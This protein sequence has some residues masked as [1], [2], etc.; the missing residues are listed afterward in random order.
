MKKTMLF[1]T[2]SLVLA[3][4]T[5]CGEKSSGSKLL[6][7]EVLVCNESNYQ[8]D[9]GQH[10]AWV[11]IFNKSYTSADLAGWYLK[12]HT[13]T[14]ADTMSYFIP[15]GDVLT[16]VKPRQHALFWADGHPNKG[17]FHTSFTLD[18]TQ[19]NWIGL[20]DG[21]G[22]LVDQ[23]TV[24][25]GLLAA[26]Q[27]Y[28]R[29]ND[30]ADEWEVKGASSDKY[31]TPS[32][33][34]QTLDS[35]YKRDKFKVQDS[36]GIGMAITAM[37]VVFSGL[38][39]LFVSFMLAGRIALNMHHRHKNRQQAAKEARK[40][41]SAATAKAASSK[42][43]AAQASGKAPEGEVYAAIAMA[44]YELQANVHDVESNVLT[45]KRTAPSAW[46]NKANTLRQMPEKK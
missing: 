12:H 45:I 33:N 35:N 32:T 34:N 17:T 39:I 9:Y 16:I 20:Y 6:L 14:Q 10:S 4:L 11:E 41:A 38:L 13:G 21:G 15:K 2:L 18:P 1:A 23:V 46:S 37:S 43:D 29:I 28:A 42:Q 24:K 25:A 5:S 19:D 8:D 40:A 36:T 30:A 27:S 22:R 44:L 26:D 7:N 3:F 31:V